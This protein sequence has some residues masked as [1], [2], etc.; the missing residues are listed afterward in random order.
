MIEKI[1]VLS[2]PRR[3]D[4]YARHAGVHTAR[5]DAQLKQT[6]ARAQVMRK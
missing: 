4:I 3:G 5:A 2:S 1:N 6:H